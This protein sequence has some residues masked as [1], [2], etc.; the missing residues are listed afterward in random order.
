MFGLTPSKTQITVDKA[1]NGVVTRVCVDADTERVLQRQRVIAMVGSPL[2]VY[3]AFNLKS[4]VPKAVRIALG[5]MGVA[6]FY[7]HFTAYRLVKPHLEK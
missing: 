7:T 3:A 5:V 2:L 4:N 1:D 6:C